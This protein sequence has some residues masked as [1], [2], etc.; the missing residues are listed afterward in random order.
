[1][2]QFFMGSMM[3]IVLSYLSYKFI[4]KPLRLTIIE[5]YKTRKSLTQT[6]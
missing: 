2:M 4:E 3:L 1:M 5:R 6:A